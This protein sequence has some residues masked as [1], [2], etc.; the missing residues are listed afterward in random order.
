MKRGF[1]FG[2]VAIM[3]A[4]SLVGVGLALLVLNSD[5]FARPARGPALVSLSQRALASEGALAPNF[6]LTDLDGKAVSLAE[7]RGQPMLINFWASWCPPCLKETPALAEA[8]R[9][10]IRE[11]RRVVFIGVGTNDTSENL[12]RFAEEQSIPYL[13]LFDAEAKVSDVY[14][15]RG[16]PTTFFVDS[17]GV[18]QRIWNG[19]LRKEQVLQFMRELR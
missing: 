3:L 4:S 15:V 11:G 16:M 17:S 9:T 6:T 5:W 19:E 13:V 1:P 10:L 12:R 7:L 8:Y 14:G 2:L 18:I